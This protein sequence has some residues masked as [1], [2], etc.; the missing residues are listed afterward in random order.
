MPHLTML[1]MTSLQTNSTIDYDSENLL[2]LRWRISQD[3]VS[4]DGLDFSVRYTVS[5]YIGLPL[6]TYSVYDGPG[7]SL[8][9]NFITHLGYFNYSVTESDAATGLGTEE[10]QIT[11]STR[12]NP[13]SITASSIYKENG[14]EAEINFCIRLDLMSTA[15]TDP[16][17][18][19]VN[20]IETAVA[21]RVDLKDNFEIQGQVVT[22]IDRGVETA[23]DSFFVEAFVCQENGQ[24]IVDSIS[25]VQGETVTVCVKP[26]AQALEIGF[27]MG[28][29][30]RFTFW[31]GYV[32]QEAVQGGNEAV[33]G[34]TELTCARGFEM[35]VFKTLLNAAFFQGPSTVDGTGFATLQFGSDAAGRKLDSY[36][37]STFQR[38]LQS[39]PRAL[40][41]PRFQIQRVKHK[42]RP[43][44]AVRLPMD[45]CLLASLSIAM[46]LHFCG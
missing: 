35:C 13:N 10:K 42:A 33:N 19:E 3:S 31:Q 27:R 36:D 32:S 29:I 18:T 8:S 21:L 39:R 41:L 25:Y 37:E 34:L 17:A 22:A 1:M 5:D 44:A 9:A 45:A 28:T 11:F 40:E 14:N 12:I 24:R 7:C 38:E 6:V 4:Y 20:H 26:T 16:T 46:L 23:E 43:S 30:D 15:A 2:A